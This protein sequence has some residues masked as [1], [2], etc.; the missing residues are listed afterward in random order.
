MLSFISEIQ[1]N[2]RCI[3]SRTSG[4]VLES[5]S[6]N[7]R[8]PRHDQLVDRGVGLR[9]YLFF[10]RILTPGDI[11]RMETP[12][13]AF[14]LRSIEAHFTLAPQHRSRHPCLD[15]GIKGRPRSDLLSGKKSEIGAIATKE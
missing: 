7:A 9:V 4:V 2:G 12:Q 13:A 11:A 10:G 3:F 15:P 14:D 8:F 6:A 5:S 1:M